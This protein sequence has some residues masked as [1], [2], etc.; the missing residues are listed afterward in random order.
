MK[1]RLSYLLLVVVLGCVEAAHAAGPS[2]ENF[3]RVFRELLSAVDTNKDGRMSQAECRV[4]Y[5]SPAMAEKN[6][7]FW[8]INKD[9]VVTEAEYVKQAWNLGGRK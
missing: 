8:D 3:K 2:D 9:G 7:G 4:I 5:S 6:C 1:N